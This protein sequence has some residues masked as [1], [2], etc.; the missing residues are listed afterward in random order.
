MTDLVQRT[1]GNE[2]AIALYNRTLIPGSPSTPKWTDAPVIKA[3][4]SLLDLKP[5]FQSGYLGETN[6]VA[7]SQFLSGQ[8]A[9]YEQGLWFSE[10]ILGQPPTFAGRY[11]LPVV[12]RVSRSTDRHNDW[13]QRLVGKQEI[14]ELGR[15]S[16]V[17]SVLLP[18]G[19][20]RLPGIKVHTNP[21]YKFDPIS[22]TSTRGLTRFS[23]SSLLSRT[24]PAPTVPS[25]TMTLSS[26]SI[27]TRSPFGRAA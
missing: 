21:P 6:A 26:T 27:S 25:S 12:P 18:T 11:S 10:T 17:P 14:P 16:E 15:H 4:Q 2:Q 23:I 13:D 7:G 8:S 24:P 3:L 1:M 19:Q 22:W 5:Y 9:Y 20:H